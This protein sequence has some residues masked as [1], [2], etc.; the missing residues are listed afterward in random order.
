MAFFP[1]LRCIPSQGNSSTIWNSFC[2]TVSHLKAKIAFA[3]CQMSFTFAPFT[4]M[5]GIVTEIVEMM[6]SRRLV[7][8][9]PRALN[10]D[11]NDHDENTS[12]CQRHVLASSLSHHHF[13]DLSW[14]DNARKIVLRHE[15]WILRNE[16][17][18]VRV[19]VSL[20]RW[21]KLICSKRTFDGDTAAEHA[22]M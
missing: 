6:R 20:R 2:H 5:D 9:I 18:F 17:I 8:C 14:L 22:K 10:N 19:L 13:K 21:Q 11:R 7:W 4:Q 3:E 1:R 12:N 16:S 15:T